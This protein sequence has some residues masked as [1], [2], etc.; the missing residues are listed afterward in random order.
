MLIGIFTSR[1]EAQTTQVAPEDATAGTA[2]WETTLHGD[3]DIYIY[4]CIC[5]CI[6]ICIYI[7]I[8]VVPPKTYT[9]FDF[10]AIYS[11]FYIFWHIFF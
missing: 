7:Y 5:I 10:T 11:K 3:D 8:Y 6:C 9:P 1:G 2:L 4:I